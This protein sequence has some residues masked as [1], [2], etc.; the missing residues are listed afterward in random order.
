M[1]DGPVE[2]DLE[3]AII[4]RL[5]IERIVTRIAA[6]QVGEDFRLLGIQ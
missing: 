3:I 1:I 5:A 2:I 6:S 4:E